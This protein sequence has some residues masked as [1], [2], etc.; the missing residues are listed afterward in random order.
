M[1]ERNAAR[2][3]PDPV[4][5]AISVCLPDLMAGQASRLRLSRSRELLQEPIANG[6]MK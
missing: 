2:V 6:W 3:L 4:G 1:A 5:A